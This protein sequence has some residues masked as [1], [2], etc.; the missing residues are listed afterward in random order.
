MDFDDFDDLDGIFGFEDD[1]E[2]DHPGVP[3]FRATIHDGELVVVNWAP[4][5]LA[6]R[7][8]FRR[9]VRER[10]HA[11]VTIADLWRIGEDESELI[12]E[13]L[14]LADRRRADGLLTRWAK[15]VG[16]D[17]LWLPDR[18]VAFESAPPLGSA[19]VVCPTCGATWEDSGPDFWT[20]VRQSGFFPPLCV[21]CN[22][23]L[24]QWHWRPRAQR[25]RRQQTKA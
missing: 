15:A 2:P 18:L 17:R 20:T 16:Y 7:G 22:S 3:T 21:L 14:A 24:P 23:D 6:G 19:Q 4:Y 12:V 8:P 5:L 13:Y 1:E 10:A 25:G 9:M 11:G